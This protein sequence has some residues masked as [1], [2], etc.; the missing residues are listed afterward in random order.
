M[1]IGLIMVI[2]LLAAGCSSTR[3]AYNNAPQLAGWWIDRYLDLGSE[4]APRLRTALDGWF[5]WHRQTQL[6]DY[7]VFLASVRQR[8]GGD[9]TAE[10]L[11]A[12]NEEIRQRLQPS[13]D[14][15]IA[16]ATELSADVQPAQVA[17]MERRFARSNTDLR[18]SRLQPDLA[19][20]R[21]SA[22]QRSVERTESLYGTV[23]AKQRALIESSVASAAFDPADWLAERERRQRAIVQTMQRWIAERPPVAQR[24]AD[25]RRL[26]SE[27]EASPVPAYRARQQ[28]LTAHNCRL[29][30]AVHNAADAE[31]RAVLA[32]KLSGWE[33]D[34]RVLAGNAAPLQARAGTGSATP[35][36]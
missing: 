4:Q 26:V 34:F 3:L 23:N 19:A 22:V 24:E 32:S 28:A 33:E 8:A 14:R 1:K 10:Q 29:L 6:Q 21:E 11:C 35:A 25:I 30:A 15:A 13:F 27:A 18:K 5:A 31:Q 36:R 16:A 7:A 9:L 20:R 17:A 2:A 12:W